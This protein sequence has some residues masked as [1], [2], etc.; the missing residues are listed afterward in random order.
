MATCTNCATHW[1][2]PGMI[3]CPIC[4]TA[5]PGEAAEAEPSRERILSEPARETSATAAKRRASNGTAVLEGPKEPQRPKTR[6]LPPPEPEIPPL[7]IPP[8]IEAE[9]LKVTMFPKPEKG[10]P[11]EDPM[12]DPLS[13]DASVA[14]LKAPRE[15]APLPKPAR[16]LN[17]PAILGALALIT[18]IL[19]P[20]TVAFESNRIIGI[21]GFCLSGF[22]LPFAPVAWIAGLSAE[23][24]RRDQNLSPERRV[25][26]GRMLGQAGTL[27]LV[28][29]VTLALILVAGL[30]LSGAFPSSFWKSPSAW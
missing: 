21:I 17:G 11:M 16:P 23:K 14:F 26:V 30:R 10:A 19:F 7:P 28:T 29:E 25:V 18:A 6:P 20:V 9:P 3:H 13:V 22:F 2:S 8:I 24:R 15:A 5:V 4:G 1:T 12:G 27:L